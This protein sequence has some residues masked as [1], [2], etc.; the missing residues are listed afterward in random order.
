MHVNGNNNEDENDNVNTNIIVKKNNF[1]ILSTSIECLN[2][3]YN[4]LD[5]FVQELREQNFEFSA[6]CIQET[7]LDEN[8]DLSH[9][10]LKAERYNL[11]PLG[12]SCSTKGGLAIYLNEMFD[13]TIKLNINQ[14]TI[15]EAQFINVFHGGLSNKKYLEMCIN[16]LE[17]Y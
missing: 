5:I 12:K 7:W 17:I 15:W 13:H 9:L 6:I 14:S 2:A 1:C 11:I 4:E 16:L 3:K 8:D 10:K